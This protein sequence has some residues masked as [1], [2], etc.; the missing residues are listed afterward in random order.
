VLGRDVV[1]LELSALLIRAVEKRRKGD[2]DPRLLG[3]ASLHGRPL[4][5]PLL[6]G[7]A[8]GVD[9]GAG[10]LDERPRQL[11]VEDRNREVLGI[12]LGVAEPARELSR[13]RDGLL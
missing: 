6:D 2:R 4:R 12:D 8:D 11:L 13:G 1:V 5:K 10:A 3:H 9:L 7:P